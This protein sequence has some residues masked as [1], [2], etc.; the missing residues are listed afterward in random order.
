MNAARESMD[1]SLKAIAV[2][3]LRVLGFK[4]S[5]PHFYRETKGHVDLACFQFSLAGGRF[6]VELSF[7]TPQR[8]NVYINSDAPPAKLRVSQTTSRFRLG[9]A[10]PHSDHWFDFTGREPKAEQVALEVVRL[11]R[12]QGEAWWSEQRNG[13]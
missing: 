3:A 6:V 5:F 12:T 7:A 10:R 4:G 13:G 8:K 9:S 11:L 2:P 1:R